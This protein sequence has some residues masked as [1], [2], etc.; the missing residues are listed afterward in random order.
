M[1]G[2]PEVTCLVFRR[3]YRFQVTHKG[4]GTCPCVKWLTDRLVR[5]SSRLVWQGMN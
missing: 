5:V 2:H 1:A 4:L 3:F